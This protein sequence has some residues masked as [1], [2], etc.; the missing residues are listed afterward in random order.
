[1]PTGVL[2]GDSPARPGMNQP[3]EAI[4]LALRRATRQTLVEGRS[5]EDPI[6]SNCICAFHPNHRLASLGLNLP[7]DVRG[8]GSH[9]RLGRDL[10][11][12]LGLTVL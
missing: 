3:V 8:C 10:P 4:C 6:T 5:D 7:C 9:P 11:D 12:V 2:A 1:M